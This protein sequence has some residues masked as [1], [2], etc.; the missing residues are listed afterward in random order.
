MREYRA[1][2]PDVVGS[3]PLSGDFFFLEH[4]QVRFFRTFSG[5]VFL[6]QV[7]VRFFKYILVPFGVVNFLIFR[8]RDSVGVIGLK[9][10]EKKLVNK[11]K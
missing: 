6:V 7:R 8:F 2:N 10:F 4:F 11:K 3:S 5:A 1:H 9:F